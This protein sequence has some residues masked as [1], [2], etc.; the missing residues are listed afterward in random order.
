MSAPGLIDTHTHA[1]QFPNAGIGME[2]TLLD[3]LQTYTFPTETGLKE[4]KRAT[5]VYSRSG[6]QLHF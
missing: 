2:L 4:D 1:S 3:W 5:E 6:S